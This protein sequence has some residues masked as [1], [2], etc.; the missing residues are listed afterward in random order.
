MARQFRL[1]KP[2]D[3]RHCE[4][5]LRITPFHWLEAMMTCTILPFK[6]NR[7][8]A[9]VL[10]LPHQHAAFVNHDSNHPSGKFG[11]PV[12]CVESCVSFAKCVL[13][14]VLRVFAIPQQPS[15]Y[16][17]ATLEAPLDQF[18]ECA[19]VTVQRHPDQKRLGIGA[20]IS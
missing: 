1:H 7:H 6:M 8:G 18:G 3:L 9:K 17:H 12:E 2:M 4:N 13:D 10:R 20:P 16:P 15:W 5:L 11:F 14:F 19:I